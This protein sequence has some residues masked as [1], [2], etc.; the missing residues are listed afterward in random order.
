MC[1]SNAEERKNG[2]FAAFQG[3]AW[4]MVLMAILSEE[5]REGRFPRAPR[6]PELRERSSPQREA[7]ALPSRAEL[8]EEWSWAVPVLGDE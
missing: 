2:P 5:G 4:Y 6:P 3:D 1:R 8:R 7:E